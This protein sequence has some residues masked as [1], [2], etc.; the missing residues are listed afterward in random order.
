LSRRQYPV[1]PATGAPSVRPVSFV[2]VR[3]SDDYFHNVLRSECVEDPLNQLITIDN[4]SNLFFDNLAQ[5]INA[6]LNQ[7]KH[8][9]IAVVHEDVL[10]PRGWQQR[11]ERSLADLEKADPDWGVLGSVGWTLEGVAEGH[12]SDPHGYA[13]TLEEKSFEAVDRIDEQLMILR[14]SR[15][16]QLDRLLPS[17]HNI[18]RDLPATLRK[19]GLRTYVVNAPT[20]HKFAD[21]AGN[22][23]ERVEDS[24]KIQARELPSFVAD[25]ACCDE[26]LHWKWKESRPEGFQE[27][28]WVEE[29]LRPDVLSVLSQPIVLL[30]RGGS[31]SRLLS[32]L[33]EGAG[34]FLGNDVSATGDA[35]EMVQDLYMGVLNTYRERASWQRQRVVPRIRRAA[36]RMLE[37]AAP[38]QAPWGFKLP[39]SMLLMAEIRQAFAGARYLHLIRDP[40]TTC[41]RRTHMT[42]RF[43]NVI[44]QVAIRAAYRYCGRNLEQSLEDSPALRMAYTTIHQVQTVRDFARAH[45]GGRY[46]EIRFEDLLRQPSEKLVEVAV[47]L[48]TQLRDRSKLENDVDPERATRPAA[49][50][51]Y[52]VE[53]EQ[54]VAN[55]LAPLRR[56]LGYI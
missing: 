23:I 22:R 44:G 45:L 50:Y 11:L 28:D 14:R 18:G 56:Q 20:I 53:I 41:L 54:A 38:I 32:W 52:P 7:A 15:G 3:Y 5:A 6:G 48:D 8:E 10:L 24:P 42:A 9:L 36:A 37:R 51:R 12:W 55:I 4:R 39:E 29:G 19:R 49:Q 35:M 27:P 21:A 13:N 17:I 25:M 43:D 40:L 46:L 34:V 33:A 16:L 1:L 47:W 26:Y 2:V 31:G 30:A